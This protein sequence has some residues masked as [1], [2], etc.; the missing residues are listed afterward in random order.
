M[1]LTLEIK[2]YDSSKFTQISSLDLKASSKKIKASLSLHLMLRLSQMQLLQI[3]VF[4]TRV[5]DENSREMTQGLVIM[6]SSVEC[7]SLPLPLLNHPHSEKNDQKI[8]FLN[9][10]N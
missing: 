4:M 3:P 9:K 2:F 6:G 7:S 5:E 1:A 8:K 10:V